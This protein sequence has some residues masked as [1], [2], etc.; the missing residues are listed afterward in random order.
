MTF[1]SLLKNLYELSLRHFRISNYKCK[2]DA[3]NGS[4]KKFS[5]PSFVSVQ[6]QLSVFQPFLPSVFRHWSVAQ[7]R[8]CLRDVCRQGIS[9]NLPLFRLHLLHYLILTSKNSVLFKLFLVTY[10]TTRSKAASVSQK[11][12]CLNDILYQPLG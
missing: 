8:Q 4:L 7:I 6:R 1:I 3:L 9:R 2:T 12:P 11:H 10:L 5:S